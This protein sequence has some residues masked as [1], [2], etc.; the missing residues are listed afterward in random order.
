[1]RKEILSILNLTIKKNEEVLIKNLQLRVYDKEI[2]GLIARED[3]GANEL[4]EYILTQKKVA[5][6]IIEKKSHLLEALSISENIFVVRNRFRKYFIRESVLED[7]LLRYCRE[8]DIEL[9]I[10][11]KVSTL[12]EY[13]RCVV[14]L[15]K[16]DIL[17]I[18]LTILDN[19]SNYISQVNLPKF[20]ALLKKFKSKGMSFIY[21]GYHHQEVFTIADR[22]ALLTN[23]Y[24]K[25]IFLQHEMN[26][27]SIAPY[28]N[29][30]LEKRG[31]RFDGIQKDMDREEIV[32]LY[33]GDISFSI[34]AGE[35]LTLLD[36]DNVLK[37]KIIE[38]LQAKSKEEERNFCFS[39]DISYL[40]IPEDIRNHF[41][42]KDL[43]YFDNLIFLLD[44]KLDKSMLPIRIKRSIRESFMEK[45]GDVIDEKDIYNLK[46]ID[47]LRLVFYKALLYKPEILICLQPYAGGDVHC[48]MEITRLIKELQSENIAVL[49]VSS[50]VADTMDVSN[51]IIVMEN[52]S[53]KEEIL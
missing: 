7:Q 12:T 53:C 14:E 30:I 21:I 32:K 2:I 35:C 48:R 46:T 23:G 31:K 5:T 11:Q 10:Y 52:G 18:P 1:M 50:N 24:I 26:D 9:N 16:A 51:R 37:G 45:V 29:P 15:I 34:R 28:I 38:D 44:K 49:I 27:E 36:M 4:K 25:K 19:L 8:N 17:G 40:V 43:N 39:K 6:Y 3:K 13:E 42:F 47:L 22:T 33:L 20:H 41:L